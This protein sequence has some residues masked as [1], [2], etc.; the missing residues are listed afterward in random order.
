MQ[1]IQ[2]R[3][4]TVAYYC[5]MSSFQDLHT[6]NG[7]VHDSFKTAVESRK[8]ISSDEEWLCCM[9]DAVEVRMP[10]QLQEFYDA[11]ICA[12]NRPALSIFNRFEQHLIED[13]LR[14]GILQEDDC[15][16]V[17]ND[18]Q[19]TFIVHDMRCIDLGLSK[20][21]PV[22]WENEALTDKYDNVQAT[23][24]NLNVLQY[25]VFDS[26]VSCLG[27]KNAESRFYFFRWPW[28]FRQN[29][30]LQ[31]FDQTLQYAGQNRNCGGFVERWQNCIV[32]YAC[33]F[34]F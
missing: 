4:F 3:D 30:P 5:C 20:C 15:N 34:P 19:Q 33:Q 16:R 32:Y 31:Y 27:D 2:E 26:I 9:T 12:L 6:H 1:Y 10:S 18:I 11:I 13:Y 21:M 22:E 24:P 7:I 14:N 17:L 23:I 28:R 29:T 25:H 8:L